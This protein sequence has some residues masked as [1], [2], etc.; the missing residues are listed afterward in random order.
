MERINRRGLLLGAVGAG[1]VAAG[2][3]L[4]RKFV[5]RA[6]ELYTDEAQYLN[7]LFLEHRHQQEVTLAAQSAGATYHD[8][9][10]SSSLSFASVGTD[11]YKLFVPSVAKGG[12][13]ERDLPYG[14]VAVNVSVG[15]E[16]PKVFEKRPKWSEEILRSP[17]FKGPSDRPMVALTFDDGYFGRDEI[18]NT[19]IAQ[20]VEATFFIVGS[21]ISANR[22][23]VKRAEES[24][25]IDWG[26]HTYTHG[27][28]TGM[29]L[30]QINGELADTESVLMEASGATTIPIM[31][32]PGGSRNSATI[33]AAASR[34][35]R[36][37]L[38]NVSGDA[39][40]YTP[41]QLVSLY[42][43][44]IDKM[45]NPWGSIILMHFRTATVQALPYIINGLKTRGLQPVSFNKLYE[46][47]RV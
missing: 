45:Q 28:L 34:G 18:L 26:N 9:K 8:L 37:F 46:G 4:E 24:G 27:D 44:Q 29:T 3:M 13:G 7:H 11:N 17:V 40:T 39:G 16:E 5:V 25:V 1:I 14:S 43:G 35:F 47:G 22:G 38:W 10:M 2:S 12:W 19:I 20:K 21:V 30:A 31:R 36:T 23:F 41:D 32:P 6:D 33:E 42:L 15:I